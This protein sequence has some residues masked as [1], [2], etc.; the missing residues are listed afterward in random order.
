MGNRLRSILVIR[1]F[2]RL[3]SENYTDPT[4][5]SMNNELLQRLRDVQGK[6]D[7]WEAIKADAAGQVSKSKSC[8]LAVRTK[9]IEAYFQGGLVADIRL[10]RGELTVRV[11][12][13]F[14][15]P[16]AAHASATVELRHAD[17]MQATAEM[18]SCFDS[19]KLAD[20]FQNVKRAAALLMGSEKEGIQKALVESNP[21][22]L[23]LEIAVRDEKSRIDL[24]AVRGTPDCPE[25][26]HYEVKHVS[27]LELFPGRGQPAK[28]VEQLTR[29]D[30]LIH[31]H[32]GLLR[33]R[34]KELAEAALKL[35]LAPCFLRGLSPTKRQYRI[36]EATLFALA[37]GRFTLSPKAVLVVLGW[38]R[39]PRPKVADAVNELRNLHKRTVLTFGKQGQRGISK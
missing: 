13:K 39:S 25:I 27:N 4:Y 9:S 34:Y 38:E 21:N 14:L 16:T 23:D 7:W 1:E 37:E 5:P 8:F 31:K 24:A 29:Y 2:V 26:V 33:R 28:V 3:F 11:N 35:G 17:E 18:R 6:A 36:D 20:R 32:E 19:W 22:I 12:R 15:F 30:T 10:Q